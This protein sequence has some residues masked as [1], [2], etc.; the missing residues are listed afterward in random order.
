VVDVVVEVLVLVGVV[1][2]LVFSFVVVLSVLV[3]VEVD[4]WVVA[5]Q[6]LGELM[7]SASLWAPSCSR[8]RRRLS[9]LA[10]RELI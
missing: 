1:V 9:T 7:T 4:A 5:S 2:L 6:A 10:G 3:V 8:A